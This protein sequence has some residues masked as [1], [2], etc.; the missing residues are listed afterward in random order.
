MKKYKGIGGRV[1]LRMTQFQTEYHKKLAS[2]KTKKYY[3]YEYWKRP[4][5]EDEI[6]FVNSFQKRITG[7]PANIWLYDIG[8]KDPFNKKVPRI[9]CQKDNLDKKNY[10]HSFLIS[11]SEHPQ[12]LTK[13]LKSAK[14]YITE[15]KESE[16]NKVK[17]WICKHYE[18][19]IE[20]WQQKIDSF[21]LY[22][23]LKTEFEIFKNCFEENEIRFSDDEIEYLL[24]DIDIDNKNIPMRFLFCE[25]LGNCS[26]RI[27]IQNNYS[28]KRQLENMFSMTVPD[29]K[30][31]G[32]T[33]DLAEEDIDYFRRFVKSNC[34]TILDYW[35]K[36]KCLE[37]VI[38]SCK[39]D[40]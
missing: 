9:R 6:F 13:R 20:H 34:K 31:I 35:N 21:E 38:E 10:F 2:R 32:Y 39:Y 12:I 3:K 24:R 16:I 22:D 40:V 30:I 33:Y 25:K 18:L 5:K 23:I 17:N 26:P 36:K 37:E 28:K 29:C 14:K 4:Y 11:I 19:L 15:L 7:L 27:L 1:K 8:N